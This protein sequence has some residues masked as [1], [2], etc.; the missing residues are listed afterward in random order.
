MLVQE[1]KVKDSNWDSKKEE[2][3]DASI[4]TGSATLL[5]CPHKNNTPRDYDNHNNNFKGNGNQRNHKFNSKG[6]RNAHA[7]R[8]GNGRPPKKSI[9]SRYEKVNV[10][11]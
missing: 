11:K 8:N 4:V 10:V 6:K 2:K 1:I 3:E 7:T 9:N 5:E